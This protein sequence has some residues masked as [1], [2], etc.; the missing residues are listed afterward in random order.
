MAVWSC[1]F[2]ANAFNLIKGLTMVLF[3]CRQPWSFLVHTRAVRKAH[4]LY[5]TLLER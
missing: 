3:A 1:L 4:C 2:L 5:K